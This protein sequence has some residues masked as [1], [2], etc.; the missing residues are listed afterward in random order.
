MGALYH[1]WG[2]KVLDTTERLS[3]SVLPDVKMSDSCLGIFV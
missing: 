1:L 3:L 2:R